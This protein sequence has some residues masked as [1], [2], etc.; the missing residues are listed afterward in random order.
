[1]KTINEQ[2]ENLR[3][4]CINNDIYEVHMPHI[5]NYFGQINFELIK[6][7]FIKIF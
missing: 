1:M 2:F 6:E 3:E 7:T 4:Y 5:N